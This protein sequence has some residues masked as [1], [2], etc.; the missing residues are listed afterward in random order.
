MF[1]EMLRKDKQI[2]YDECIKLLQNEF[3]GVLSFLGD[4]DYPYGIPMNLYYNHEDGKIYF[5]CGRS[6]H[7][8]DSLKRHNKVSFCVFDK[9]VRD[10]GEWAYRIKSV[11]V[12]GTID[13]I[14]DTQKVSDIAMKLSRKFTDDEEYINNEIKLYAHQTL[15]LCL[16][17]QHICGKIVVES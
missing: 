7:K 2:S 13:I 10:N 4:N 1:R 14:D 11:I 9:G 5:H 17:P 16:N 6:G 8:L 12:F 15:L 3:R